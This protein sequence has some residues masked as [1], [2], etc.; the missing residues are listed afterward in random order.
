[1]LKTN[2]QDLRPTEDDVRKLFDKLHDPA[3]GPDGIPTEVYMKLKRI[4]MD[5]FRALA[6]DMID[7]SITLGDSFNA[8]FVACI[9]KAAES[10]SDDGTPIITASG[11]RP[12]SIVDATNRIVAGILNTAL[13]R[14]ISGR[15]SNVQR[16]FVPGRQIMLNV[17][18]EFVRAS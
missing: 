5:V 7:G 11:T 8:A 3:P 9:P 10:T 1:M 13:E 16:G 17:I 6:I 18:D 4:A 14:C 2:L 15:I 12:L